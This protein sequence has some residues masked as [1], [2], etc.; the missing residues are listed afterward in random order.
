[1]DSKYTIIQQSDTV[2]TYLMEA[3]VDN[4]SDIAELPTSWLSGS[5]C[6]CLE[7]SSVWMLSNEKTW[8]E[9]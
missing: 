9:L 7:D 5:S 1:M 2:T 3:V 6:L 4:R 8:Q